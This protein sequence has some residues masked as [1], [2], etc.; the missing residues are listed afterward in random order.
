M[1]YCFCRNGIRRCT[2][3]RSD[4]Q[5][6]C[7]NPAL[8]LTLTLIV[9]V[10]MKD[11]CQNNSIHVGDL[12][13]H[14]WGRGIRSTGRAPIETIGSSTTKL[15]K[16]FSYCSCFVIGLGWYLC[17]HQN[18]SARDAREIAKKKKYIGSS[19]TRT[20]YIVGLC[21]TLYCKYVSTNS[22]KSLIW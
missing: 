7:A 6:A 16:A 1:R 18:Y 12:L 3:V 10:H 9:T 8:I 22:P 5:H 14:R 21:Y 17:D 15:R 13:R 2:I 19:V 20:L 4:H 11:T